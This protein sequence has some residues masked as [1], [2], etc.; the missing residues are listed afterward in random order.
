MEYIFD[1]LDGVASSVE[2]E[3]I[4]L[5]ISNSNDQ[6]AMVNLSIAIVPTIISALIAAGG[7]LAQSLPAARRDHYRA[8]QPSKVTASIMD[9]QACLLFEFQSGLGLPL[10][11]DIRELAG[12]SAQLARLTGAGDDSVN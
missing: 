9:N 4:S 5:V 11:M 1:S 3:T 8:I 7:K 10:V 2:S 12:L 6:Q